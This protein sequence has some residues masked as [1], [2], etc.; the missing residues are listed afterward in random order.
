MLKSHSSPT[1]STV[2]KKPYVYIDPPEVSD[3][4]RGVIR[5]MSPNEAFDLE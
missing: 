3:K 1:K 5:P 4:E 2:T